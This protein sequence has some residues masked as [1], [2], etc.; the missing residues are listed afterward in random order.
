[1]ILEIA[2][3]AGVGAA[4]YEYFHNS[5]FKASVT[6]DVQ[7]IQ[8]EYATL[9]TKV[10]SGVKVAETDLEGLLAAGRTLA[11]KL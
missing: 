8:A 11:S 1:M 10:T 3:V 4:V 5:S 7:A 9:H 2:A 6:K